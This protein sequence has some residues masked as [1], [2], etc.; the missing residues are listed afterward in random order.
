MV[1]KGLAF[2]WGALL[3][4]IAV[5]S[6]LDLQIYLPLYLGSVAW[7]IFYDTIYAHQDKTDD[8]TAGIK[9]TAL[10]FQDNTKPVL[11]CFG[12]LFLTGLGLAG[13]NN[14]AGIPFWIISMGGGATH[15]VWQLWSVQLGVTASCWSR[16]A[17]NGNLGALIWLGCISDYVWP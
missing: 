3:G 12:S 17:S 2:N 15:L 14:G 5:T 9:S 8:A 1:R 16:F 13:Y 4:P 6:A 10:L 7:T 11:A